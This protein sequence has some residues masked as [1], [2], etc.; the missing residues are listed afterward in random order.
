ML[1]QCVSGAGAGDPEF[2][3]LLPENP[4]LTQ[5]TDFF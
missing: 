4:D 3:T 1:V 2:T 5:Y